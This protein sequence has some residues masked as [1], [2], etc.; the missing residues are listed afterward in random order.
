MG[1]KADLDLDV[2]GLAGQLLSALQGPGGALEGI[3]L[4]LDPDAL[5][6][7]GT[8]PELDAGG[9]QGT[10]QAVAAQATQILSTLPGVGDVLAPLEASLALVESLAEGDL[11]TRL[12][13]LAQTLGAELDGAS[14]IMAAVLRITEVLSQAP[15][16]Q[17]VLE[18]VRALSGN[19]SVIPRSVP[20]AEVI[21]AV[22]GGLRLLAGLM[23][24]E[25]VLAESERLTQGMA[26]IYDAEAIAGGLDALR[27]SLGSDGST[28]AAFIDAVDENAPGE[29]DAAVVA[30]QSVAT[31]LEGVREQLAAAMGLGE[32]T[33]VYLDVDVVQAEMARAARIVREA[34]LAPLRRLSAALAER[35][36]PLLAFDLGAIGAQALDGVLDQAEAQIAGV[37]SRIAALDLAALVAPVIGGLETLSGV[38]ARVAE[39]VTGIVVTFQGA[40]QQVKDAI[41]A[42]P[43][44]TIADA[45]RQVLAP[46]TTVIDTVSE[47]VET[48]E[49]ALGEAAEVTEL[50]LGQIDGALATFQQSIDNLFAGARQVVESANIDAV[51][52]VVSDK[53]R[54]FADLIAQAQLKPYFDTA[55][56]AID[57]A[58]GVVEAVPFDLVPDSMKSDV[59]AAVRPIKQV[60]AQA[61]AGKVKNVLQIEDGEFGLRDELEAAISDIQ[62]AYE[63]LI[64]F[65]RDHDP[66]IALAEVDDRLDELAERVREIDP[67]LTLEPVR[68]VVDQVKEAISGFDL[69]VFLDPVRAVFD[70]ILAAIE[71]YSPARFIEPIEQ[72]LDE[73]RT[74]LITQIKLDSW[75]EVLDELHQ[76]ALGVIDK[77]DPARLES[78]V[79]AALTELQVL[80]TRFPQARA[81]GAFGQVITTL[82]GALDVRLAPSAFEAVLEWL[83]D[84]S[85]TAALMQRI[86]SIHGAVNT[87]AQAVSSI[88]LAAIGTE[89]TSRAN[90]L[91]QAVDG[92]IARLP[93]DSAERVALEAARPRLEVGAAL[94]ALEANRQR[95]AAALQQTTRFAETLSRTGLSEVDVALAE[96]REVLSPLAQARAKLH[97]LLSLIGITPGAGVAGVLRQVLAVAPPARLAG[98]ATP[99]VQALRDR[100]DALLTAIL[101][102]IKDGI[103]HIRTTVDA[104]DLTPLREAV[105]AV[106]G[107]IVE[108]LQTLHPDELL[109][110]PIEAFEALQQQLVESDP[111]ETIIEILTNLRNLIDQVLTKLEL[112]TLLASPLAIYDHIVAELGK[113]NIEGLLDPVLDQLD[114]IA[115]QVDEGLDSTVASFERLQDALPEA[116]GGGSGGGASV[117]VG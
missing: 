94:G 58:T 90:E 93:A 43:L 40:M 69:D 23:S 14:G 86:A 15:E 5:A 37:A 44:D 71:E 99:I 68:Q 116:G 96:L 72:R 110:E 77:L 2:A 39:V 47:V 87:V 85:G 114:V 29:V 20:V 115:Q 36:A 28:L 75:S 66:R 109:R 31:L 56:G 34:A 74:A 57:I 32:A 111:L 98:M 65:I 105:D 21:T 83:H 63:E 18:I 79:A 101:T 76:R 73:A 113:L 67:A 62:D 64:Q 48:I 89:L 17:L 13:G 6:E 45:I 106:V 107:E 35:I 16:G 100:I 80:V 19:S 92:L 91:G 25:T 70:Q 12:S 24:L 82:L 59:D 102:P 1:L 11:A 51:V 50:A 54:E 46:I 26:Q 41:A 117:G 10:V 38:F 33:L 95:Y 112:E 53:I 88:D 78:H 104:I 4:P 7:V 9:L 52:G 27:R 81:G 8:V 22:E 61:F 84:G 60:D 108:Q 103:G 42:L 3:S 55:V 30:V 49:E 97:E